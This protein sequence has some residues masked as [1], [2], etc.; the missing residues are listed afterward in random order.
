MKKILFVANVAKEHINKFH[1]PSIQLFKEHGWQVD[2]ACKSDAE[3]PYCDRQYAA[4]WG[5]SPFTLKTFSGIKQLK[6]ILA[7]EHYDVVYCHTPVG[8]F[9]ARI[10]AS[11]TRKKG[12]KI[13]YFAHGLHFFK[14]CP[15]RHWV[16]YPIEKWLSYKTDAT[17]LINDEDFQRVTRKFNKKMLVKQFPGIGVNFDRLAVSDR[18]EVR[19]KYRKDLHISDD[20]L[21]LIYIAELIPNK[22]QRYLLTA[23][24]SIQNDKPNVKLLLVGPDHVNGGYQKQV[25][26][27][28]LSEHVIFTGWRDDIGSLLCAADICVASSIREGFGINLVEAMY[29]GLPVVAVKNRGHST[30]IK[31][32]ENGFLVSLND[33][34]E[35]AERVLQIA[36][37]KGLRDRLSHIDVTRYDA[38]IVAQD[39]VQT[40]EQIIGV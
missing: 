15:L 34:S 38:K 25:T 6:K 3:V 24:K 2:V 35:M 39:V 8:G 18:D 31:D 11:K 17:I 9:V 27:M 37:D 23:L 12:T 36:D 30:V 26:E 4:E 16:F 28:G 19:K 32:G 10:A 5:R 1:L 21:V 20:D 22:N 14:D 33:S 7:E 40:V 13:I 29:M